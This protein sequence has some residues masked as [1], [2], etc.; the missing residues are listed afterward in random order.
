GAAPKDI[1]A[2]FVH[3]HEMLMMDLGG[4][5]VMAMRTGATSDIVV[6]FHRVGIEEESASEDLFMVDV[7]E[8]FE[9]FATDVGVGKRLI[10]E[11]LEV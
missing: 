4:I 1:V 11:R 8:G 7:I 6:D 5:N 2:G 9:V 10:D 3:G